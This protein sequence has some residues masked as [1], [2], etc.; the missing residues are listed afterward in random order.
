MKLK[1]S[2]STYNVLSYYLPFQYFMSST[3]NGRALSLYSIHLTKQNGIKKVENN[4][5]DS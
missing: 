3:D 1:L 2:P 4:L 5:T